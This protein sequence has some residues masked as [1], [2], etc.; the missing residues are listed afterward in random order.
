[1]LNPIR[2][3]WVMYDDYYVFISNGRRQWVY[4]LK[5]IKSINESNGRLDPFF[6]LEIY[7]KNGEIRKVDFVP[8]DEFV[9]KFTG[10]HRGNLLELKNKVREAKSV[11]N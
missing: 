3:N 4:E 5:Q 8:Q 9:Y 11:R 10:T 7:D 2:L 6:E 1:M